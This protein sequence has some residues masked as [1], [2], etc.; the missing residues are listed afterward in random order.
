MNINKYKGVM[1]LKRIL[2]TIL[3][4]GIIGCGENREYLSQGEGNYGEVWHR[5]TETA[6]N[7]EELG[8]VNNYYE[9]R[10]ADN[11][12]NILRVA[13]FNMHGDNY[14]DFELYKNYI[15]ENLLHVIGLQEVETLKG[16]IDSK[17]NIYDLNK[18]V[19]GKS[20][21]VDVYNA[22][23]SNIDLVD[24]PIVTNLPSTG[25][26]RILVKTSMILND[27]KVSLYVTHLSYTETTDRPLQMAKI[28]EIMD[29]D[30]TPYKILMGDFNASYSDFYNLLG[31]NYTSVQ[32]YNGKWYQTEDYEEDQ[33]KCIDNI[34]VTKNIQIDK[35]VMNSDMMGSDHRMLWCELIL[36]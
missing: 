2:S 24:Q 1:K 28:K 15:S 33:F 27:K 17:F 26:G 20:S 10:L 12:N 3:M 18:I 14:L 35:V 8:K 30:T 5:K 7:T 4:S 25:E 23:H 19:Y 29:A 21:T 32:G 6:L 34:F 13:T 31:M 22:I 16:D 11:K 9:S 36:K